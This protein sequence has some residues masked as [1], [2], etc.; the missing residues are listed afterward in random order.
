MY[1]VIVCEEWSRNCDIST[2]CHDRQYTKRD[3]RIFIIIPNGV[4]HPLFIRLL[5]KEPRSSSNAEHH[6]KQDQ[7]V[8]GTR[9]DQRQ[10]HAEVV[11]LCKHVLVDENDTYHWL[12]T[13]SN[14][15][16]VNASTVIPI[17]FVKV[18]PE[19]T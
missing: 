6:R 15:E 3:L 1:G 12:I 13:S 7:A 16:R 18:I 17:N 5:M 2:M 4:G 10:P 11:R 8:K 14:F 9:D 19:R